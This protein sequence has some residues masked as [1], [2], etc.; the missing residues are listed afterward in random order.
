MLTINTALISIAHAT[1]VLIVVDQDSLGMAIKDR[2][3]ELTLRATGI[4]EY[5][6]E[7]RANGLQKLPVCRL[8]IR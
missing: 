2:G 4:M 5:G 6:V 8:S 7:D 1:S 3:G